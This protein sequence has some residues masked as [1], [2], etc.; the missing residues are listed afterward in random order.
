MKMKLKDPEKLKKARNIINMLLEGIN[1]ISY[2]P[3][4]EE[5]FL[6]DPSMIRIFSYIA[7]VLNQDIQEAEAEEEKDKDS[8]S[9]YNNRVS[10]KDNATDHYRT[11]NEQIKSS[12]IE[13]F[14]K[15][16]IS[17]L[18]KLAEFMEKEEHSV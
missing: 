17:D 14:R 12:K 8:I 15:A 9:I 7:L 13:A 4:V 5:S 2:D 11:I 10:A 1:P 16:S 3:I 18:K 6:N